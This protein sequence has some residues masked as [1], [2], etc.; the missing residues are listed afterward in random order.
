MEGDDFILMKPLVRAFQKRGLHVWRKP[1]RRMR[2][3]PR[4]RGATYLGAWELK[5]E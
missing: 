2:L 1:D 3:S 4:R 5:V